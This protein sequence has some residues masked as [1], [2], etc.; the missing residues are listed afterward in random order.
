MNRF[1]SSKTYFTLR[2]SNPAT[3]PFF[4]KIRLGPTELYS[5]APSWIVSSIS[6]SVVGISFRDSRQATDTLSGF[7]RRAVRAQSIATAPPPITSTF[8]PILAFPV[9]FASCK[10]DT[11]LSTPPRVTPSI[12][13]VRLSSSPTLIKM[14]E[15]PSFFKLSKVM[16]APRVV[17]Y[18]ISTPNFLINSTSLSMAVLG[19]R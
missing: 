11:P 19:R 7:R 18:L 10:K 15:K 9:V 2:V 6:K 16:S 1:C 12:F 14:V 4:P 5:I 13:R 8:F 3:L 17:L